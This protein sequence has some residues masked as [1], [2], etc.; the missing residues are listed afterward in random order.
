MAKRARKRG[1]SLIVVAAWPGNRNSGVLRAGRM[2]LACAL[3]T[4][5]I[6]VKHR[7]GDG[8][9]PL[10][11]HGTIRLRWR[12]D[13]QRRPLTGLPMRA[14]RPHDGWCDDPAHRRYNALISLPF[15]AS[16]ETLWRA[17][18]VYD[19]VIEVDWN[20]RPRVRG[21]GSAIFI[22]IARDGF[23]PTAGCIALKARDLCRLLPLLSLNTKLWVR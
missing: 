18:G 7:E 12:A 4:G 3:G 8:V 20:I 16:H 10:G 17:D 15:P 21:R 19:L 1:I 23:A 9:T 13:R 22:H 6:G 14:I 5:G 11:R 2:V